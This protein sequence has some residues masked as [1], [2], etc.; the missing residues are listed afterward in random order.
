[1]NTIDN[2]KTLAASVDRGVKNVI[3]TEDD[4]S[5]QS[6]SLGGAESLMR[7]IESKKIRDSSSN[8]DKLLKSPGIKN[9]LIHM[10]E[11]TRLFLSGYLE[12]EEE[13]SDVLDAVNKINEEG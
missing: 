5:S 1:M 13:L 7:E 3:K 2:P 11:D 12:D 4:V 6:K 8:L 10:A 9:A